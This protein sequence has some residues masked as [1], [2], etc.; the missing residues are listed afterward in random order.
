MARRREGKRVTARRMTRRREG[1]RR[2]RMTA[3]LTL[4]P[5]VFSTGTRLVP[6]TWSV[7]KSAIRTHQMAPGRIR[8]P[9]DV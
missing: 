1:K 8:R 3:R 5:A 4:I 2:K 6:A 7:L 9:L